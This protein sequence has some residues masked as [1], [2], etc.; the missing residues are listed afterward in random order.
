MFCAALRKR[1]E[2]SP[3]RLLNL[4]DCSSRY[5]M[6]RLNRNISTFECALEQRPKVFNAVLM[7]LPVNIL[8]SVIDYLVSVVILQSV[9][10]AKRIAID[11]R[12]FFNVLRHF[13][14]QGFTCARL[15]ARIFSLRRDVQANPSQPLCP[16]RLCQDV[17]ACSRAYFGQDH[18]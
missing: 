18:R 8:L 10:R 7:D 5:Q 6:E 16:R 1:S 14:V 12:A 11:S 4:N 3:L 13:A 2:S 9:V 17:Y 15:E